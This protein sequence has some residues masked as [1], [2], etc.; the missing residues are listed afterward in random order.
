M[1]ET[2][3]SKAEFDPTHTRVVEG[4][5]LP[6]ANLPITVIHE[7]PGL[8]AW[9]GV[10]DEK[11]RV[12]DATPIFMR[13]GEPLTALKAGVVLLTDLAR[14]FTVDNRVKSNNF[15][16]GNRDA[17]PEHFEATYGKVATGYLV[18]EFL[19]KPIGIKNARFLAKRLSRILRANW[20]ACGE[21]VKA[22]GR[23]ILLTNPHT[24]LTNIPAFTQAGTLLELATGLGEMYLSLEAALFDKRPELADRSKFF[25][26]AA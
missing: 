25:S 10:Q 4:E 6:P 13:T 26:E 22:D 18:N 3:A 9:V 14:D 19:G 5:Y 12:L 11:G 15:T 7:T 16:L 8:V 24:V 2:N 23:R 1:I 20:P 17:L 21:L